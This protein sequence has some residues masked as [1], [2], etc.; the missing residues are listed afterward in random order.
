[1]QTYKKFVFLVLLIAFS[2]NI[3]NS[4]PRQTKRVTKVIWYEANSEFYHSRFYD[5]R[6]TT[7]KF[8][9]DVELLNKKNKLSYIMAFTSGLFDG[10][11][12]ELAH[13]YSQTIPGR[14][15]WPERWWNPGESWKNKYW[16]GDPLNGEKFP[17]SSTAMVHFTDAWHLAKFMEWNFIDISL[18]THTSAKTFKGKLLDFVIIR[19]A[20]T[21]GALLG[22]TL[23]RMQ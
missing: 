13:H 5:M 23:I 2:V 11:G 21:A 8:L 3:C 18:I 12:D 1:M 20:K 7:W 16:H 22:R 15:N 4:Q 10:F 6:E 14:N 19:T 17:F 9:D